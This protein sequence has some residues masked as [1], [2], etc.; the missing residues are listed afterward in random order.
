MGEANLAILYE[1]DE[2]FKPLFAE[3]ERREIIFDRL[4][5]ASFGFD[6]RVRLSR[7]KLL[8]NRMSPSAYLRGHT[9]A[10]FFVREFLRH[11]EDIGVPVLNGSRAYEVETSKALQLDI[12][13]RLAVNY[14]RAR[15]INHPAEAVAAAP[16]LPYPV[17]VKTNVRG[18]A[19]P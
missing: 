4:P 14:P 9:N 2:W 19:P 6:P 8:V 15:V 1:H 12:F 17:I 18:S 10:I 11:V 13:E 5:A 16:G 7:Y 3:L